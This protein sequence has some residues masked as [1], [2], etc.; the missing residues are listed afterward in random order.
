MRSAKIKRV[1]TETSVEVEISIDGTGKY[2]IDVKLGFLKHMLEAFS[3]NG[4]FDLAVKATGDLEVD[5]HHLTEDIAIVLGQAF[6]KALGDKKGITRYGFFVMPMDGAVTTIALDLSGRCSLT[7]NTEFKRDMIGDFSTELVMEFWQAF[8]Q[9]I[10]MN[11][12]IKTECGE[13]THHKIEG[14]FKGV[15]RALRMACEA[16]SRMENKVPSTKGVL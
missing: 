7:M 14:I 4:L 1:T 9:N 6:K 3:K 5:D 12:Y 2:N 15:G 13:N 16:D 8:A 11:L 10:G